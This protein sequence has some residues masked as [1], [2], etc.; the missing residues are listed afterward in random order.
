L[1]LRR[2][3]FFGALAHGAMAMPINNV[4]EKEKRNARR[5]RRPKA[6]KATAM[7]NIDV[8]PLLAYA[9]ALARRL[10]A[11]ARR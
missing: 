2:P 1:G 10:E 4:I 6:I 11:E 7:N 8:I 3:P 5:A 9:A